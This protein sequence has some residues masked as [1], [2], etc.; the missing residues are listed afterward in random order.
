[1][2]TVNYLLKQWAAWDHCRLFCVVNNSALENPLTMPIYKR[3]SIY[4]SVKSF[5]SFCFNY[6][7]N[8]SLF[9]IHRKKT[10]F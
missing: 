5:D 3:S 9:K 10:Q 7:T 4:I 1:M 8:K 6:G 2:K